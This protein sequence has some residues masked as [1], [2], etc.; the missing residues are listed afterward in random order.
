MSPGQ[1]SIVSQS[2]LCRNPRVLKEAIA[3]AAAGYDVTIFTAIY[4]D[5]LYRQDLSLLTDTGIGYN[6]YSDLRKQNFS[7]LKARLIRKFWLF[8]QALGIESRH[9]LG[10]D[11]SRLKKH[12]LAQPANLYIMHQELATVTGS[13]MVNNH[14]VA[15]DIEDWYSE[16]L[17][18][19]ARK[20]RPIKLLKQAEKTAIEKGAACYTTSQAMAKGLQAFY[21]TVNLPAVIY[22]SFNANS[23]TGQNEQ[24][25][26]LHLYWLS[27]TIG[28]GRGLEF[29]INCMAKS[30]IKCKL[31]LRG[32]VS[33]AYK[34]TLNAL[35]SPKDSIEFLP[36]LKNSEIQT[37]MARYDIG[38]ALE[39]DNPPNKDLTVS[40]KLFHYMAAGLP[41]IASYTRGQAEIAQ[42]SPDLIW[43]YKQNN[44]EELTAILNNLGVKLKA[45]ELNTLK[46]TVLDHY[47]LH[48]DW[49]IEADKLVNIV[50]GALKTT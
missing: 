46:K 11:A 9:S 47:Q 7:S 45:G 24:H 36:M 31:S 23:N 33:E 37:D 12:I 40:N 44:A 14:K 35:L 18:P 8:A 28:E 30:A 15:F 16:D 38:L 39:P 3:L 17:L 19:D 48:F 32:N 26:F 50:N 13:L 27:Q 4:S 20:N 41:V 2:H 34:S 22:N 25:N 49:P 5:D 6:I 29:F 43:L 21:K 1:I 10:Y 42:Q